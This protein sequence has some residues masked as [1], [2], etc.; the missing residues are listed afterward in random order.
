MWWGSLEVKF[1]FSLL[2]FSFKD[3]KVMSRCV[4]LEASSSA[5]EVPMFCHP[6]LWLLTLVLPLSWPRRAQG[7][8]A[9]FEACRR[10]GPYLRED[11]RGLTSTKDEAAKGEPTF[12]QDTVLWE[13]EV[14]SCDRYGER[15]TKCWGTAIRSRCFAS[16]SCVLAG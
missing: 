10:L 5:F 1:V 9:D 7:A 11:S 6:P 15:L 13:T 4:T 14:V 16:P 12:S 3:S 2:F 8:R